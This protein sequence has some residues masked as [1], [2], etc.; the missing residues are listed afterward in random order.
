MN[1]YHWLLL[2]IM[3]DNDFIDYDM[4]NYSELCQCCVPPLTSMTIAR[5]AYVAAVGLRLL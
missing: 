2:L 5:R 3:L 1:E 4:H